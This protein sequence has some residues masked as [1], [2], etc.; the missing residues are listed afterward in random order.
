MDFEGLFS[1]LLVAS[2]VILLADRLILK[3]RRERRAGAAVNG[4]PLLVEYARS[5]F[6]VILIVLLFRSFIFEPFRIPS[7][8]MMPGLVDGDFIF[9]SNFSCGLRLPAVKS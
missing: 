8:S 6:P 3:P 4:K 5:F 2:G 1:L 9:V 7:A